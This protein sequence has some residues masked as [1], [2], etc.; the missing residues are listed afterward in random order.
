ME[1]RSNSSLQV[2]GATFRP[3]GPAGC[4]PKTFGATT[5]DLLERVQQKENS[6]F[7]CQNSFAKQTTV[8]RIGHARTSGYPIKTRFFIFEAATSFHSSLRVYR[9]AAAPLQV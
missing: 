5:H 4:K 1:R 9:L 7:F 6:A 2:A 3:A 8:Y